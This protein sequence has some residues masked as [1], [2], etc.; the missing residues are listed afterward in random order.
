MLEFHRL[1]GTPAKGSPLSPRKS[2]SLT[3]RVDIEDRSFHSETKL[4]DDYEWYFEVNTIELDGAPGF[5][6]EPEP[7]RRLEV[8]ASSGKCHREIEWCRDIKHPVEESRGHRESGDA[9]SPGWFELPMASGERVM[10]TVNVGAS[11][12]ATG[13]RPQKEESGCRFAG[14]LKGSLEHFIVRR[15]TGKTAPRFFFL[16]PPTSSVRRRPNIYRHHNSFT[17]SHWQFKPT[18]AVRIP[19]F[20]MPPAFL[21][22]MLDVPTPFNFPMAFPRTRPNFQAPF[23]LRLKDK[24]RRAIQLYCVDLKIP[25]IVVVKFCF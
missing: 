22:W 13:R 10:M 8:R 16:R 4:D 6:F 2:F 11:S 3:V 14:R 23:W 17:G 20:P 15:G 5:V 24:S 25:F 7:K 19:T 18:R 12:D 21:H 1:D 9:Y